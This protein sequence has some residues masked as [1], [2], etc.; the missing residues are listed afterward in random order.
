MLVHFPHRAGCAWV[1]TLLTLRGGKA[2]GQSAQLWGEQ[3]E[4]SRSVGRGQNQ[5]PPAV[6]ERPSSYGPAGALR[7]AERP[8]Q[9]GSCPTDLPKPNTLA[10]PAPGSFLRVA[11]CPVEVGF[12]LWK[13]GTC[14][15]FELLIVS[16]CNCKRCL[17]GFTDSSRTEYKFIMEHKTWGNQTETS[18]E[19]K[20]H[21]ELNE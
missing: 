19:N 12:Y 9:S 18:S 11:F 2:C 4:K 6:S 7:S 10:P 16:L 3:V 13:S 20:L 15:R 17:W 14:F 5:P 8:A 21:L 1:V